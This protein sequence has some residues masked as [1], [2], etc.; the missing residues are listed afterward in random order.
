MIQST[1]GTL[2]GIF[3]KS[4]LST[5]ETGSIKRLADINSFKNKVEKKR[6]PWQRK[7]EF[8]LEA[9]KISSQRTQHLQFQNKHEPHLGQ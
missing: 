5:V 3:L 1:W 8:W 6:K 4:N 9:E 7:E 2:L